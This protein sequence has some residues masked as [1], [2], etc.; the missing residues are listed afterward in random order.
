MK[1]IGKHEKVPK[2]GEE[3]IRIREEKRMKDEQEK[4]MKNQQGKRE[5]VNEDI[6]AA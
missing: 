1:T 3:E 5:T 4:R 2:I 6:K